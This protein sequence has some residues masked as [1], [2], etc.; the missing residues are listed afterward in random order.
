MELKRAV[1]LRRRRDKSLKEKHLKEMLMEQKRSFD[2][3]KINSN[4]DSF[5]VGEW[6]MGVNCYNKF[7]IKY[8]ANHDI[9]FV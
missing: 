4:A 6:V 2:W 7:Y 9:S 3:L 5:C 1:K 8:T